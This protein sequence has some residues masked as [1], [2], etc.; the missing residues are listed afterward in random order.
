MFKKCYILFSEKETL[1]CQVLHKN[2]LKHFPEE[3]IKEP[4]CQF[5]GAFFFALHVTVWILHS[6]NYTGFKT[7]AIIA[8]I[9]HSL[10]TISELILYPCPSAG[11]NLT[12]QHTNC[13]GF[14]SPW[15]HPQPR[16]LWDSSVPDRIGQ[17]SN[18]LPL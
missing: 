2:L 11:F 6:L 17:R 18:K 13:I 3:H 5:S 9:S 12:E 1:C 16:A 4:L 14:D 7:S 10:A 15:R 8:H